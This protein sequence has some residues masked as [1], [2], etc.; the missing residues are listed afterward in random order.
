MK[1]ILLLFTFLVLAI[2]AV[3]Q[4]KYSLKGTVSDTAGE[5]LQSVIVTVK[6][7]GSI[8]SETGESG[9]FSLKMAG[10]T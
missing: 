2:S 4:G 5:P 6:E 10:G 1:R 3:A 8:W 7:N 9:T